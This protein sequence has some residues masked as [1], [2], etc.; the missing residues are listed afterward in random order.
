MP[1]NPNVSKTPASCHSRCQVH[2]DAA[3][4]LKHKVCEAVDPRTAGR[5]WPAQRRPHAPRA[6][7]R[8]P[9]SSGCRRR[10]GCSGWLN[11][12][13]ESF[14]NPC[15]VHGLALHRHRVGD[16]TGNRLQV[17]AATFLRRQAAPAVDGF[18]PSGVRHRRSPVL[19]AAYPQ[20]SGSRRVDRDLVRSGRRN[21]DPWPHVGHQ[22]DLPCIGLPVISQSRG[23][24][25]TVPRSRCAR[26]WRGK[27]SGSCRAASPPRRWRAEDRNPGRR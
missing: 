17:A 12:A 8:A 25:L 22:R 21:Q 2:A 27:P 20:S 11:M 18:H 14:P 3:V 23:V 10:S 6:A 1:A 13:G 9:D 4:E 16:V 7:E 26:R 5:K 24:S 19:V 15:L